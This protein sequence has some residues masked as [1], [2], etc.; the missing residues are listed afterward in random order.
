MSDWQP[1]AGPAMMRARAALYQQIR[2]FF[3]E[4]DYLEIDPPLLGRAGTTDPAIESFLACAGEESFSLQT[5][6]EFFMKRLLAAGSGPIFA[7]C[8]VFRQ[9]EQ[10][11]FHNPEFTL[12][13]W[14]RPGFDD[15]QLMTEVGD[16]L[17]FL[18]DAPVSR[19]SY[20]EVFEAQLGLDPHR[21]GLADLQ[22]C[23]H[24][25]IDLRIED[26]NRDLWLD[27]L[28]SHLIQPRLDESITLIYDYP[29]SQAALARVCADASGQQVARRFEAFY[30]GVEL[31]NGY[32]E[33]TDAVEQ[34]Q[35]FARDNDR[36][37]ER[38]QN[39][40][41]A[42][43]HLLAALASGLPDCA[44][45][46]LGVDRLLMLQTGASHLDQVIDFSWARI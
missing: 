24:R 35:R 11:R 18:L 10:G 1:G 30:K 15:Q 20:R 33:L 29:A 9:E 12:L 3:A 8:K 28:F 21:A 45:V 36:R 34:G 39:A 13:E 42:D 27:L 6:P 32:W 38:G 19:L 2:R 17:A 41:K 4:R 7:L 44:G 31:A 25:H 43:Q 37:R 26:D 5:S 22:A 14:Y 23:A 16:L 46:A 40:V